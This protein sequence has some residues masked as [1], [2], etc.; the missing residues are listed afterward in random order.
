EPYPRRFPAQ[1]SQ[2]DQEGEP[3]AV[4][5]HGRAAAAR[6]PGALRLRHPR[7]LR[8]GHGR[9]G[10]LRRHQPGHRL[11][12]GFRS[13]HTA[14]HP[15]LPRLAPL[16]AAHLRPRHRHAAG[17]DA[18][19]RY[20][21]R[22]HEL[23]RRR[24]GEGAALGVRQAARGRRPRGLLRREGRLRTRGISEGARDHGGPQPAGAGATRPRHRHGLRG[25]LPADGLRGRRAPRPARGPRP[26]RRPLDGG[27]GEA[28]HPRGVP[29]R[30]AHVVYGPGRGQY[31]GLPGRPV[32]DGDRLGRH[33]GQ[34]LRRDDAR[35]PR[36]P[37]GARDGLYILEPGGEGGVRREHAADT[38]VLRPDLAHPA[39]RDDLARPLRGPY[40]R[41]H[42]HDVP[43]PRAGQHRHDDGNHAGDGHT[44]A[45]YLLRPE[46]PCSERDVFGPPPEHRDALALG[47]LEEPEGV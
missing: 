19:G 8:G 43:L 14:R 41:G 42:R 21:Q 4:E 27:R 37:A 5:V 39:R 28:R 25:G 11:F 47:G 45:V 38:V 36:L 29:G 32:Q 35:E 33:H 3:A 1:R 20:G 46:L 26:R 18:D 12:G 30:P 34:G 13:R 6:L 44:P 17:G 23:A 24:P 9:G 2:E 16:S 15:R 7:R 22:R 40:S 31:L 10:G